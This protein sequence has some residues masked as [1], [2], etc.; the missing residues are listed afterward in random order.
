MGMGSYD[1]SEQDNFEVNNIEDD[2]KEEN[3][4]DRHKGEIEFNEGSSVDELL[5]VYEN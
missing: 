4:V 1:E 5:E 3:D 2:N